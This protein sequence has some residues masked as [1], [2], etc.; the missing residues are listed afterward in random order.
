[1]LKT[2]PE[3]EHLVSEKAYTCPSC[4][5][6]LNEQKYNTRCRKKPRQHRR[7]PNGFGQISKITGKNLTNPYRAMVT[8]DKDE[9]GRPIVKPLRPKAYFRTYNEAYEALM[10][11]NKDPY[12]LSTIITMNESFNLWITEHTIRNP[13]TIKNIKYAWA[14]CEQIHNMTVQ[15]VRSRHLNTLFNNPYKTVNGEKIYAKSTASLVKSTLNQLCDYALVRN[16]MTRNYSREIVFDNDHEGQHH[17]S[18][19]QEEIK[20][21]WQ[22]AKENRNAKMVLFQCY[23]GWRPSEM[24]NI[25][26]SDVDLSDMTITGG[27]KTK[28]G[29][30]RVVP[31]HSRVQS[32]FFEFWTKSEGS[33]WLFPVTYKGKTNRMTYNCYRKNFGNVMRTAKCN[34]GHLPHDCRK[35]F[36]TMAK[37]ANMDEYALKRIVGHAITDITEQTY[38]DRPIA[39]LREEIEKIK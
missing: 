1:M 2:C 31:I 9:T 11:Y 21:L 18:F 33:E 6:P 28:S 37:A 17:M 29:K 13:K 26:R 5:F 25:K 22:L 3:C 36:I 16:L 12:D 35:H 39:W 32:I 20:S 10:E 23:T 19:T 4:G 7:L 27:S 14:Y 38:T 34:D 24:L 30:N 15:S 8:V